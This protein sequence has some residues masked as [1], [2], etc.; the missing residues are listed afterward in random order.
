LK[1]TARDMA[2]G[3]EQTVTITEST[4]LDKSEIERMLREAE[5][6]AEEDR[7]RK[8]RVEAKNQTDS[9]VYQLEK[10]LRELGDKVPLHEKSRCEKLI[11]DAKAA[12]ND[13]STTT[14]RFKQ[15]S[16]DIQQALHMIAAAAYQQTTSQQRP[17][18]GASGAGAE[19]RRASGGD[20][21]ID[22]EFRER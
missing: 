16:S 8:E 21:V 6:Y 14:E 4:N 10:T 13:D 17:G 5:Q 15:L 3:K 22:A 12:L 19:G 20:D 2:T 18:E 7:K 9:M 11:E 1:V